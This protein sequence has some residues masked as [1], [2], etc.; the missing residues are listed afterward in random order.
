MDI[1][2]Q[3]TPA[4]HGF[5]RAII[6]TTYP[7]SS[8]QWEQLSTHLNDL[9]ASDNLDRLNRLLVDIHQEE[10]AS[11]EV[12]HFIQTFLARYISRGRP[13]SGYFLVCCV[14]E[15][16][17]TVLAQALI[18]GQT[19]TSGQI[20]EADAANKAW[21]SL[22]RQP[23]L[24]LHIT[25]RKTREILKST[26]RYSMQCFTDLLC[27]IEEMDSEPTLDTYAWE[28]MS[29]S[30]VCGLVDDINLNR[31]LNLSQKLASVCSVALGELDESLYSRL[32]LLLSDQS[33]ISENLV[34]EAAL[35]A[36]TVLIQRSV[37]PFALAIW[38][39]D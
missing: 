15:T 21:L 2:T 18:P 13:L 17:W 12:I 19:I 37:R 11:P 34:Q 1:L 30:L 20:V 6:S 32:A 8:S 25:D 22:M 7:W 3:F 10:D 36:T 31:V 16:Q 39:T 27:Q 35:K 23:V 4:L 28:T 24:G 29:E 5:Y 14:I 26:M 9:V 33:P 38:Y